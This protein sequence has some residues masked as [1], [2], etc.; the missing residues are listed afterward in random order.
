MEIKDIYVG[1]ASD[2]SIYDNSKTSVIIDT[3]FRPMQII[4]GAFDKFSAYLNNTVGSSNVVCNSTEGHCY[5]LGKCSDK[6]SLFSNIVFQFG[7]TDGLSIPPSAYLIDKT[8]TEGKN[9]CLVGIQRSKNN[10]YV[11]G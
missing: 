9:G 8:S 7:D 4:S 11:I 6:S 3:F 10:T 5:F 1:N 2:Y